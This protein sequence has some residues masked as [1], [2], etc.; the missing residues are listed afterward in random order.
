MLRV[1][2]YFAKLLKIINST[3]EYGA[4]KSLLVIVT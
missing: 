3:L 1:I 2:E 4:C